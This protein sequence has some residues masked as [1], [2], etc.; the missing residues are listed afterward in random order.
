VSIT[1]S[2]G[3]EHC[4]P[5]LFL[6]LDLD[7]NQKLFA[8]VTHINFRVVSGDVFYQVVL[9]DCPIAMWAVDWD[10]GVGGGN[11]RLFC[12]TIFEPCPEV[13]V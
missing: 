4:H 9:P 5:L 6:S 10:V 3:R 11:G 8:E 12:R 7:I 1:V 2:E 13:A